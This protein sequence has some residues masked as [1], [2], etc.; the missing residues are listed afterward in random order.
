MYFTGQVG[1]PLLLLQEEGTVHQP[2]ALLPAMQAQRFDAQGDIKAQMNGNEAR[3]MIRKAGKALLNV[4]LGFTV[5][6]TEENWFKRGVKEAVHSQ[7]KPSLA[8]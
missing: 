8:D 4:R 1:R 7:T 5:L 3:N 6:C 2:P